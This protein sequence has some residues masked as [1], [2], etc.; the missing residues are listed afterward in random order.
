MRVL[1]QSLLNDTDDLETHTVWIAGHILARRL[2]TIDRRTIERVYKAILK[3]D[4][5]SDISATM[6]SLER[7]DWVKPIDHKNG[8]AT[9]WAS[10]PAAHDG[11]FAKVAQSERNRR[12]AIQEKIK[13]G[14]EGRRD[15]P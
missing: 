10:N 11:R 7:L 8:G 2:G 5:R 3:A 4:Q 6:R 1:Y 14:A 12:G 13:R 9:D 15:A